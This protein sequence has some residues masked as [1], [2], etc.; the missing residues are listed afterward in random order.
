MLLANAIVHEQRFGEH[1]LERLR[2]AR[3]DGTHESEERKGELGR[4][5]DRH[6][7]EQQHQ[8]DY[9]PRAR[10]LAGS[11][12]ALPLGSQVEIDAIGLCD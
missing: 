1:R 5:R 10:A 4:R 8:R 6:A 12:L 2:K 7:R 9:T 3:A 11:G